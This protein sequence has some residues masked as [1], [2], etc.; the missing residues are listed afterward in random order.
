[1][2]RRRIGKP[3]E[4]TARSIKDS[5]EFVEHI[6]NIAERYRREHALDA[7]AHSGALRQSLKLFRKH[8]QALS[9]WLD[10]A[11]TATRPGVDADALS[12][13]AGALDRTP[14]EMRAG[15]KEVLDW[16]RQAQLAAERSAS[17]AKSLSRKPQRNAPRIAAE[18][19]RA[20]FEHH[21]LSLS[22]AG[23]KERPSFVV[24]L[25]CAIAKSAGDATLTSSEAK[26][27]FV[28][29]GKKSG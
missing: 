24:T 13:M 16:L 3:L 6:G 14:G 10:R 1:M 29:S 17:A 9:D 11:C 12:S 19:L 20:T 18:G 2:K 21:Q 27:V 25:L 23:S 5:D 15:G 8:A 22:T 7:G 28:A 4:R 26:R